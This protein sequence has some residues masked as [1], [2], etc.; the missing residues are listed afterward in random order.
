M[1][2]LQKM[3]GKKENTA[4]QQS[5]VS[6]ELK[7]ATIIEKKTKFMQS[8]KFADEIEQFYYDGARQMMKDNGNAALT[9]FIENEFPTISESSLKITKERF[10]QILQIAYK[11]Y[12]D[13]MFDPMGI[14]SKF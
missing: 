8:V 10:K 13:I 4:L 12:W 1:K 5:D 11:D 2:L 7:P 9:H 6:G 14:N 3:F